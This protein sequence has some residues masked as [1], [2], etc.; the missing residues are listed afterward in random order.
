MSEV[1]RL[2]LTLEP[3]GPAGAF[4]LT[5]E[6]V[7]ALG[8]GAKAFPVAVSVAGNVLSLRLARMGGENLIGLNK[9]V[10]AEAGLELGQTVAVELAA[11]T[12][13]RTVE[14][15]ADLAA[16]LAADAVAA[17]GFEKL[18]YSHRKEYVR[19]VTEAKREQTRTER[20]AKTVEQVRQGLTR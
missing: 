4:V 11:D 5:D 18:A 10:R 17:A 20:I 6:Q 7:A 3:R 19:W 16:A 14:V 2:T 8:G 9:A 12:V 15:P 1:L 13:V